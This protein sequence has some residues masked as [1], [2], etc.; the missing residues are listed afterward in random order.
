MII[1]TLV[2]H[3][4]TSYVTSPINVDNYLGLLAD[5]HHFNC[6]WAFY[7]TKPGQG[8]STCQIIQ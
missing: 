5:Y 4:N 8:A 2:P 3:L 7:Q 1:R 6:N